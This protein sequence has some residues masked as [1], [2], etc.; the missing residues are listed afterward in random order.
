MYFTAYFIAWGQNVKF[1]YGILVEYIQVFPR[2]PAINIFLQLIPSPCIVRFAF[3]D[4]LAQVFK[5][6]EHL[7]LE[8]K[9][10]HAASLAFNCTFRQ[11]S[12]TPIN[13]LSAVLHAAILTPII[14]REELRSS[15]D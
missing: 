14:Y 8:S 13:W 2:V 11:L 3:D 10:V 6:S 7:V 9:R 5:T 1:L 4:H 15:L 12:S